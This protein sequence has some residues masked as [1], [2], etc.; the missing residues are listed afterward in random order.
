MSVKAPKAE[1]LRRTTPEEFRNIIGHFASGVTVI[2]AMH[3]GEPCGATASAVSS[4]SLEPPMVLICL[5]KTS[6]TCVAVGG[7]HRFAV[8]ILG[9][10]QADEAMRFA[11]RKTPDKFAGLAITPGEWGEP[12]LGDALA[13]LECR[14][15]EEVTGGTHVVFLAEVERASARAGTPLAYFRGQFG[16]LELEQDERALRDL[17]ARVLSRD[18]QIGERFGLDELATSIGAP[19]GPVYHALTKLTGE[20]LVDR[21]PDGTFEVT[22]LTLEAVQEAQRARYAIELGVA[23]LTVGHV[24]SDRLAELRRAMERTEP[25]L[26]ADGSTFDMDSYLPHYMRFHEA[27]VALADT[28]ALVDAYRRV[29]APP[30]IISMTGARLAESGG[31]REATEAGFVHHRELVEAYEGGDLEAVNQTI[32]RHIE[33]TLDVT[34]TFMDAAGGQI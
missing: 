5:N 19:R 20:G 10:D 4:L 18:L 22:P 1:E 2:T 6:S 16:R 32:L 12:L 11:S 21:H 24:P 15:V 25:A 28:P 7:S 31:D 3:D 29:N 8:N 33:F 9:E 13:I 14:V 23:A 30:M 17:R 27:V 26:Y 34:R